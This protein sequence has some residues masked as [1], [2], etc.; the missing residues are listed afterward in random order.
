MYIFAVSLL[1]LILFS[2]GLYGVMTSNIGIKM[3]IS[4]EILINAAILN[5]V[6][7]AISQSTISP[8]IMALFGIAIGAVESVIGISLLTAT[9]RKVGKVAISLLKEIRW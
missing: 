8:I 7:V 4:I 5:L 2:I 9:Y 3:L 1:S 6:V